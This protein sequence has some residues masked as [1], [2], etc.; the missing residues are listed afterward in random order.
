MTC[1]IGYLGLNWED[2]RGKRSTFIPVD[3]ELK[4]NSAG[5][6][7]ELHPGFLLPVVFARKKMHL[8]TNEPSQQLC[9]CLNFSAAV[10]RQAAYVFSHV[11]QSQF[12]VAKSNKARSMW[13]G[14]APEAPANHRGAISR[15]VLQMEQRSYI[16]VCT[17]SEKGF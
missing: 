2:Y 11:A 14:E 6:S 12:F 13:S 1:V 8:S 4:G 3:V 5:S 9:V 15:C 16:S 10:K 17:V 7:Q